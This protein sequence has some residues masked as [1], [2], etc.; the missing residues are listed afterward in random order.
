[1]TTSLPSHLV[2]ITAFPWSSSQLWLAC[3]GSSFQNGWAVV[4]SSVSVR[5]AIF[6]AM[7]TASA[8]FR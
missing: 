2:H 8:G 5:R 3:Q 4:H 6:A 7:V 1:M